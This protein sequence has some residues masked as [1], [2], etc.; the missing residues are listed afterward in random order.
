ML[1]HRIRYHCNYAMG[2]YKYKYKCACVKAFKLSHLGGLFTTPLAWVWPTPTSSIQYTLFDAHRTLREIPIPVQCIQH[3]ISANTIHLASC[4]PY[5]LPYVH[6][7][8]CFMYT[9]HPVVVQCTYR[10]CT[11]YFLLYVHYTSSGCPM[12]VQVMYIILLALCTLYIQWLSN[13]RTGH[14]HHTFCFMY[15]IHPVVVQCMYRSCTSY[16]L[17]YVHYTSSGCPMHVQVMYIILLALCTLYIQWLSNACTGHVHHTSCFMY[18]IHPVV[19]Q[20]M[21]RSCTSYFL[22]YVHYTSSGCPMHVQVMYIILLALC[23]LYIQ[24]LSNAC[25]GHGVRGATNSP[26]SNFHNESPGSATLAN[27]GIN[28]INEDAT[29]FTIFCLND[30]DQGG[31]LCTDRWYEFIVSPKL[32]CIVITP[33][34]KLYFLLNTVFA[35]M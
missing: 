7:T 31:I 30:F 32:E 13:A 4:T 16:F 21:Y 5:L 22:L 26:K 18:T 2:K 33:L 12:H 19:V 24:W 25:T 28:L 8:S 9:I 15:T 27:T 1:A 6:H 23:T 11:S 14:V 35:D 34:R 17:L 3:N 20:C 10:S 29:F